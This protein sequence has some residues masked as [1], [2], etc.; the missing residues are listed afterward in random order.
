MAKPLIDLH[1]HTLYSDGVSTPEQVA[2][3]AQKMSLTAIA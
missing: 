1:L 2:E 3:E